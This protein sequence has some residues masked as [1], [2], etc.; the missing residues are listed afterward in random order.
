VIEARRGLKIKST[1]P[2]RFGDR[3]DDLEIVRSRSHSRGG[4][5]LNPSP[6]PHPPSHIT[7]Q[8]QT[9]TTMAAS[10]SASAAAAFK[11]EGHNCFVIGWTGEVGKELVKVRARA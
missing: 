3:S 7:N 5:V 1:R 2:N 11:A 4:A 6:H 9:S 8:P 10:S